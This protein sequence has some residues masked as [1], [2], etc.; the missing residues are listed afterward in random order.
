M[1]F[2]DMLGDP[3]APR[4]TPA[5]AEPISVFAPVPE[6]PPPATDSWVDEPVAPPNPSLPAPPLEFAPAEPVAPR[7]GLAE[8]NVLSPSAASAEDGEAA[9]E[10]PG[11]AGLTVVDD[12]LLP[13]SR[14]ARK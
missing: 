1:K 13:S 5:E 11:L 3:D 12:D 14:R 7:S 4:E 9:G 6:T 8:V 10:I 2:S